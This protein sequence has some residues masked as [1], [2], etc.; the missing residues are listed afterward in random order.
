VANVHGPEAGLQ[1]VAA[2]QDRDKLNSYY[3]LYAVLGEFEARLNHGEAAAGYFRQ[4]LEL[5]EIKSE[6]AFLS[7]RLDDCEKQSKGAPRKIYT[8]RQK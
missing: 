6:Q 1:A 4:S 5:A 8:G 3:L 7:H 2:I